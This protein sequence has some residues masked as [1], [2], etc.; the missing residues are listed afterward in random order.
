MVFHGLGQ[1]RFEIEE[2]LVDGGWVVTV[3]S[4]HL[5]ACFSTA[6]DLEGSGFDA[7]DDRIRYR[8]SWLT[9]ETSSGP[10]RFDFIMGVSV[11]PG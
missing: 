8:R 11:P 9:T 2:A 4:D 3:E 1:C 7:N 5:V 6:R 10:A